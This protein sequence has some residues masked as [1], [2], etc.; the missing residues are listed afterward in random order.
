VD[1]CYEPM[2]RD[3]TSRQGNVLAHMQR[4]APRDTI[5][6]RTRRLVMTNRSRRGV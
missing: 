6:A 1:W 3:Y 4:G 5:V 2:M